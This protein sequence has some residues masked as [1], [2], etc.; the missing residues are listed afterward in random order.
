MAIDAEAETQRQREFCVLRSTKNSPS[1]LPIVIGSVVA[2][3]KQRL[4]SLFY[5]GILFAGPLNCFC[6]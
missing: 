4:C 1:R 2:F 5:L 6:P 3:K